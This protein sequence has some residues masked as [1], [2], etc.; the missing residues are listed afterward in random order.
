MRRYNNKGEV[1]TISAKM[2]FE[3]IEKM[4][5]GDRD[6]VSIYDTTDEE[7]EKR[8]RVDCGEDGTFG[9]AKISGEEEYELKKDDWVWVEGVVYRYT[10]FSTT[11]NGYPY[12]PIEKA[13]DK[14]KN[15]TN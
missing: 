2:V 7:C 6:G 9:I 14:C 13:Y 11:Y 3:L 1:E 8:Y 10:S 5:E 4:C 15:I 12:L